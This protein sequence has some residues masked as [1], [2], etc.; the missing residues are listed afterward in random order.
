[1]TVTTGPKVGE[2][3]ERLHQGRPSVLKAEL[4]QGRCP[5]C[6]AWW[7]SWR[8]RTFC[9]QGQ[10]WF[11]TLRGSWVGAGWASSIPSD[12][13]WPGLHPRSHRKG[14]TSLKYTTQGC[15]KSKD[16]GLGLFTAAV[17]GKEPNSFYVNESQP[18]LSAL[19]QS[20]EGYG[21][22]SRMGQ[23]AGLWHNTNFIKIWGIFSPRCPVWT[24]A[25]VWTLLLP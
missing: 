19:S 24:W 18:I 10:R 7:G 11:L 15:P 16:R 25:Q 5:P 3:W 2:H 21:L 17:E 4:R 20:W 12:L 13:T 8:K 14:G 6:P 23:L 22:S 9:S 1:M